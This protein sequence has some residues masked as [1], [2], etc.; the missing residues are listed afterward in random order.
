MSLNLC[1]DMEK[2]WRLSMGATE[3]HG[4]LTGDAPPT[5]GWVSDLETNLSVSFETVR[6]RFVALLD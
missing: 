5:L 2:T 4:A 3:R 1:A 6:C